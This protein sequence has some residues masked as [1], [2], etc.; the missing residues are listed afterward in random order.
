MLARDGGWLRRI[1]EAIDTGLSAEAAVRRV[2]EETRLR[3]GHANDPYLRERLL[4]LDDLANRL[5][6]HLSGREEEGGAERPAGRRHPR[7]P[8]PLG[9][10]ARGV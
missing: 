5:L 2:Q 3:I 8:Q 6:R 1:R 10:R 4:D 7:R 9:G